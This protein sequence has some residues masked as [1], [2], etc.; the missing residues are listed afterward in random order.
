MARYEICDSPRLTSDPVSTG[1]A[2][3][4]SGLRDRVVLSSGTPMG[5]YTLSLFIVVLAGCFSYSHVHPWGPSEILVT[6]RDGQFVDAFG[7]WDAGAYSDIVSMGYVYWPDRA[8]NVAYFPLY[9]LL[10]YFVSRA[11]R[12]PPPFLVASCRARLSSR[13]FRAVRCLLADEVSW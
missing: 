10:G 1:L 4:R 13:V 8:S 7:V 5:C 2:V 12:L 9:P 3:N 6:N 11:T